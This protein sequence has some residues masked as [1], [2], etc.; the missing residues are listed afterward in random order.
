LLMWSSSRQKPG[1][2]DHRRLAMRFRL[3]REE[4]PE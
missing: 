4:A 1:S 3:H 2:P